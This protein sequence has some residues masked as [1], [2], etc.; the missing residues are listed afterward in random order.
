LHRSLRTAVDIE[1][2]SSRCALGAATSL[3]LALAACGG[4]ATPDDIGTRDGGFATPDVASLDSG[5]GCNAAPQSPN[6][7][8]CA[9]VGCSFRPLT[10]PRCDGTGDYEFYG[11]EF[12]H[13]SV[14]VVVLVGGWSVPDMME[15]PMIESMI[16]QAY[17]SR[18][19]R[20]LTVYVQ[21]P[22]GSPPTAAHCIGWQNGTERPSSSPNVPLTST[23]LMDPDGLLAS[24]TPSYTLTPIFVI[25]ERGIYVDMPFELPLAELRYDVDSILAMEGR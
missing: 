5:L 23:M 25:D 24:Y 21:D 17:A 18:G 11:P 16:T 9:T 3:C 2:P 12:C 4:A 20:V 22:D 13:A 8:Y 6:A 15:A 7:Q 14:T 10:L 19:V 1:T